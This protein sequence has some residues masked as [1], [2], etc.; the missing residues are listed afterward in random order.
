[1]GLTLDEDS[2][3]RLTTAQA[4]RAKMLPDV[5]KAAEVLKKMG[6]DDLM[7]MIFGE[8]LEAFHGNE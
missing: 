5:P 1:M 2:G 7:E 8:P 4:S 3:R 6:A